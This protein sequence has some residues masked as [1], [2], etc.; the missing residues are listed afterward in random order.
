MAATPTRIYVVTEDGAS[1]RLV[2]ATYSSTAIRHASFERF[3]ARVATQADLEK[4]ITAGVRVEHASEHP[5]AGQD[6]PG[7]LP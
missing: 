6:S 2:R 5:T 4:L 3:R 1:P 7:Q